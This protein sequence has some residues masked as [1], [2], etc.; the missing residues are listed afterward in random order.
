MIILGSD[1]E[2]KNEFK[3]LIAND[4]EAQL[5]I[6]EQLFLNANFEVHLARNGFQ[7]YEI[8]T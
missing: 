8:T 4:D 3:C 7:A 2:H 5:Q 1:E 6:L